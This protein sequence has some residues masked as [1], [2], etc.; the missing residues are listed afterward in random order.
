MSVGKLA[1]REKTIVVM[2]IGDIEMLKAYRFDNGRLVNV[3]VKFGT[4]IPAEV[5]WLDMVGAGP[6]ER[7]QLSRMLEIP[8][9]SAEA[10]EEIEASSRFFKNRYGVHVRSFFLCAQAEPARSVTAAFIVHQNLLITL[11]DGELASFRKVREARSHGDSGTETGAALLARLF[12]AQVDQLADIL[13]QVYANLEQLNQ[14]VFVKIDG[15]QLEQAM[16]RLAAS[17]DLND[18]VRLSLFDQQRGLS[19]LSRAGWGDDST[20]AAITA[21]IAD[22]ESLSSHSVFLLEKVSFMVDAIRGQINLQEN[23][24]LK[25]VSLMGAMLLPPTLIAAVYGMNFRHMP[26]LQ[27]VYGYPLALAG[28]VVVAALPLLV[29]KLRKW[30]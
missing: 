14:E 29:F 28:M 22:I 26:E 27:S 3:A 11:R 24:I 6:N 15:I 1:T 12:E 8:I 7:E 18:K 9:P 16:R 21:V 20:Q 23:R 2:Q 5:V 30:F 17:Q 19:F 4:R 25:M 10:V 13:E